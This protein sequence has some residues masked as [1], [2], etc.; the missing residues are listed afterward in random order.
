VADELARKADQQEA[1][2]DL[3]RRAIATADV[4]ELV[5]SATEVVASILGARRAAVLELGPGAKELILRAESRLDEE[6]RSSWDDPTISEL[7][8]ETLE[9]G[10]PTAQLH[11]ALGAR[12]ERK[13]GSWGVIV[14]EGGEREFGEDD[15]NFVQ[16]VANVLGAVA[17]RVREEQLEAQLQQSRRI[18]SVGKLAGGVAHDFNNLLAIILNYAD[19][20]L[21]AATDEDQRRDLEELTKAATRGAELVRQLLLF[22]RRKPVEAVTLDVAEVVRDTEPMLRRAVGEHVD[23]RCW[24]VSELPPVMI[25]PGQ[26]TQVLLNLAVNARDAMPEGGKLTIK[27]TPVDGGVRLVVEDTGFGMDEETVAKAFDPFFTTKEPGSGTGLGLATVY[28]IVTQAN[29]TISLE[30]APGHGSRVVIDLPSSSEV[31]V[32]WGHSDSPVRERGR[33]RGETILVVE[34]DEQVRGVTERILRDHGYRV[35]EAAGGEAA[36]SLAADDP[37]GID[38]LISDVVMPGMNGPDLAARLRELRPSMRVLHMSGYTSGIGGPD[39]RDEL[40]ELIE[41]PFTA[42][43]SV[44]RVRALLSSEPRLPA[45]G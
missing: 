39:R 29:G 14:V 16:A 15:V 42:A 20:A 43:D 11:R 5:S 31:A 8:F 45:S 9:A 37:I 33:G 26:I 7:G 4:D 27:G 24:L 44:A 32:P 23:L 10:T 21:E 22:S 19:F 34:D 18:E 6:R 17:A 12:I 38:L 28:G 36:L 35:L 1:V 30:S 3:G 40:P 2:A 41:K 25:D 13:D